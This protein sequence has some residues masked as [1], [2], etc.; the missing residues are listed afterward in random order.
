MIDSYSLARSARRASD[1]APCLQTSI[2]L[3]DL[4]KLFTRRER[5]GLPDLERMLQVSNLLGI[6]KDIAFLA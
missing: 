6:K 1:G 3:I 2:F 4:T 5:V